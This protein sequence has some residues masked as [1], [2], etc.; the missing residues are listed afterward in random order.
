MQL[1]I[2]WNSKEVDIVFHIN[3]KFEPKPC[4]A[5]TPQ[6]CRF[7]KDES[8][9]RHYSD[10]NEAIKNAEEILKNQNG[11]LPDKRNKYSFVREF[12]EQKEKFTKSFDG[13]P[14]RFFNADLAG[15]YFSE[16]YYEAYS[17]EPDPQKRMGEYAVIPAPRKLATR[18]AQSASSPEDMNISSET[19]LKNFEKLGVTN[20]EELEGLNL[21]SLGTEKAWFGKIGDTQ[22]VV[23]GSKQSSNFSRYS[24]RRFIGDKPFTSRKFIMIDA[25][26]LAGTERIHN[27]TKENMLNT[28]V[29]NDNKSLQSLRIPMIEVYKKVRDKQYEGSNFIAQKKFIDEHTSNKVATAWMDKK[30]IDEVHQKLAKETPLRKHFRKIEIDNDVAP[31]EFKEFEKEFEETFSKLP[32]FDKNAV[33]E[34]RIRKL[35]KHNAAGV[36]FPHKNTVCID[37]RHSSSTIHELGH[38]YDLVVKKNASLSPEFES[39][40]KSYSKGL[41]YNK[42][43]GGR[44]RQYYT[45]PTEVHSRFFEVY[46]HEKLGV[47][48]RLLD[49][50]RFNTRFDYAPIMSN[51]GLKKRAFAFF[52][53]TFGKS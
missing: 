34:L 2:N 52:D 53:K 49:K 46:A 6:S 36:F 48:N 42:D 29:E 1:D 18:L 39:I 5:K 25:R 27:A 43:V 31:A 23:A 3:E 30:G 4:R 51:E 47:D 41:E 32:E 20:G 17:N 22:I 44:N 16:A 45:T 11:S 33:P 38:Y 28:I 7:Y 19:V 14:N 40:V 37:V 10:L 9:P 50:D 12:E 13:F 8:D 21:R 24:F 15:K 26:T 35:G